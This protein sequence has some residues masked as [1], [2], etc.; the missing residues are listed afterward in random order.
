MTRRQ[1]L[2]GAAALAAPRTILGRD[3]YPGIPYREYARCLP[4]YLRHLAKQAYEARN[5]EIAKL[6][7]PE[8]VRARQQWARQT[9]WKL[10]GGEPERTPLNA[11]SL[12]GFERPGYKVEKVVY[13]S[14]PGLHIPANLYIPTGSKPPF[15]GVLFQMGHSLNGKAAAPYQKCCQ[16]LAKL[17]F[18]VLAF[19]PMGQGERT[20]YPRPGGTLTRLRSADE[21]HTLPGKQMLLLGDTSSRMQVWDAVRSLDYLAAHPMVDPKRLASTGQS[22]GGTLTMLLSAVDDRLAAAV[23]C[24]GNT[25]NIACFG[26]NPPGSTDDAEQN[27]VGGGPVTFDRWDTLY[28]LAPKPLLIQVSD[29]DFFGT[30][31][32]DYISNGWEQFRKLKNAYEVLGHAGQIDWTGTPLPHG[33]SPELRVQTYNWFRRWL[34]DKTNPITE[35]P[36]VAVEPDETLWVGRT[37]N[38]VRDFGS[39]TPFTLNRARARAIRP[40]ERG[41]NLEALLGMDP[42]PDGI[43]ARVLGRSPSGNVVVE[44]IEV[45]SAANVWIPAWLFVPRRADP[46]KPLLILVEPQGRNGRWREDQLY[47]ELAQLGAVVCAP[48]LR[49]IGDTAPEFGRGA[50]GHQRWHQEEENY[51]WASLVFG[52]SL[53]GQR[54]TD[55]VAVVRALAHHDATRGRRIVVAASGKL[56]PPA[57]FAAAIEPSVGS[58]YLASGLV[59]YA[60]IVE[61]EEF[62]HPFANIVPELLLQTDLPR[63][64]A[65][66]APRAVRLAGTVDGK[67]RRMQPEA[68]QSAYAAAPNVTVQPNPA[69]DAKTLI[70]L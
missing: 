2:C 47:Q 44:A 6:T 68:V 53:L 30:Y 36:P 52:R 28:P 18:L 59:S 66:I 35:E 21:E 50:V 65:M 19:D 55:L 24:C 63:I 9:F 14:R 5:R 31:S 4:D 1:L 20:Y 45:H 69:W 32:P 61:T 12:G 22:G 39:E 29:K 70:S 49:G 56:T 62:E 7:T 10:V 43:R 42:V 8:A 34:L 26:F 57:M 17:G 40:P 13:E 60:S 64:V 51:A 25:E 54:V 67:G 48:D 58:L 23:V 3:P 46:G 41:I 16:G 37:G 38:V 33:L 27:F 11:K 15:P